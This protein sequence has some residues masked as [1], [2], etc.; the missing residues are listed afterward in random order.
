MCE[1]REAS[2]EGREDAILRSL[3]FRAFFFL[4]VQFMLSRA[5]LLIDSLTTL[6]QTIPRPFH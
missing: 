1:S 5:G 2:R 6:N 4:N 3:Q